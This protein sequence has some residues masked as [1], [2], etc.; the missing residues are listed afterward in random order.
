MFIW[1]TLPD[2]N[3]YVCMYMYGR[4]DDPVEWS[5]NWHEI[6]GASFGVGYPCQKLKAVLRYDTKRYGIITCAQKLT[7]G[8]KGVAWRKSKEMPGA[9]RRRRPR[10]TWM[11][12]INTWT[13]LPVKE[14]I[15]MTEDYDLIRI[16]S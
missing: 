6:H 5:F 7:G 10:T 16:K 8:N 11:D 15:R 12:N 1:A 4:R 13:G 9:R 3:K 2:L 14:S